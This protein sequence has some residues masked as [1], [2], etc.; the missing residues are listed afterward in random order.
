MKYHVVT[1]QSAYELQKYL[2]SAGDIQVISISECGYASS[3]LHHHKY[4]LVYTREN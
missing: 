4:T 3:G 2:N 1:F